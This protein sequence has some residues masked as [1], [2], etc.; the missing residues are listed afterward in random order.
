MRSSS[1]T[2]K[3]VPFVVPESFSAGWPRLA[4]FQPNL[5]CPGA[6]LRHLEVALNRVRAN[7]VRMRTITTTRDHPIL[8][9]RIVELRVVREKDGRTSGGRLRGHVLLRL[10]VGPE[11]LN[12]GV[13]RV[14]HE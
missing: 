11:V 2:T 12:S 5:C 10:D 6:V 14:V 9:D 7:V 4:L 8:A 3:F 13:R 1:E